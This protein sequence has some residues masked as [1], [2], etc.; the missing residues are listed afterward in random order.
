MPIPFIS[1]PDKAISDTTQ[2]LIPVADIVDDIVIYRHGGAALIMESTSLNFGLLSEREQQAVIASYAGIL[3]SFN[4]P[5]Q[6]VVRTQKKDISS[7]INFL[8]IAETKVKN[9]KLQILMQDYKGF[10]QDAI[11]KKNV[12]SKKFYIVIPFTQYELGIAK[13]MASSIRPNKV[14]TSLPYPKSYV[15][16]KAKISLF[17]KRDH[18]I[19]Q[20]GRLGI[21][22]K[23]L[24]NDE[25]MQL[26]F[27]VYNPEPPI[28]E[29]DIFQFD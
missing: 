29:G 8:N 10:I 17:P 5:V 6:I 16:R 14:G 12:L 25:L 1:T 15:I 7:Y 21:K 23:Q 19:R 9:P 22:F 13:S 20:A 27:N 26:F 3:N 28:K 4:F 18:L 2:D 11:Q 24:K